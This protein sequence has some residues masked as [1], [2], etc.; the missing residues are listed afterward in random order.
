[1][2][3]AR[4]SGTSID[5]QLVS[6]A[7]GTMETWEAQFRARG[8]DPYALSSTNGNQGLDAMLAANNVTLPQFNALATQLGVSF[9]QGEA[10][11]RAM[12]IKLQMALA[13][14]LSSGTTGGASGLPAI[15]TTATI[16][17][18]D[19]DL[20]AIALGIVAGYVATELFL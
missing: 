20:G 18:L 10:W 12:K 14:T 9:T 13:G 6:R 3:Y 16:A 7:L 17:G 11:L 5:L 15:N 1:M 19:I 4:L 2:S 8:I